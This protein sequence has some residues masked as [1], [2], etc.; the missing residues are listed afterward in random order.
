MIRRFLTC[1]AIAVTVGLAACQTQ[2]LDYD[3]GLN[4]A[5]SGDYAAA[6]REWQPMAAQGDPRAQYNVSLFY[7][8]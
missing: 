1:F 2:N 3:A 4:A 8:G 5:D 7:I 6:L